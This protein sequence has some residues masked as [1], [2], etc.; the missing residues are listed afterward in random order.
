M[1]ATAPSSPRKP[2]PE[3]QRRAVLAGTN[4]KCAAA[5]Q[6]G[7]VRR[8]YKAVTSQI[9]ATR[10]TL[11]TRTPLTFA[12]LHTP[13]NERHRTEANMRSLTVVSLLLASTAGA[14]DRK[15]TRLNSSHLGISYA[16]FC[17]K[18]KKK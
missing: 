1:R 11:A 14:I 4:G 10:V 17:L 9:P 16:V 5:L 7:N 3:G 18:K 15:S 13:L 8:N 6:G 2:K 12:P